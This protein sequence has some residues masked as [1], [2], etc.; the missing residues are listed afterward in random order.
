MIGRL[1]CAYHCRVAAES[2]ESA[3]RQSLRLEFE[4]ESIQKAGVDLRN[5][6][7]V[8]VVFYS[9]FILLDYVVYPHLFF[10]A[11]QNMSKL[12]VGETILLRLAQKLRRNCG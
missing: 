6:S 11:L 9:L 1:L 7:I 10:R 2:I 12:H 3:P 8:V 5:T 4:R